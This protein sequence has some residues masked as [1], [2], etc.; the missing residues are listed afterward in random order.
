MQTNCA[1]YSPSGFVDCEDKNGLIKPGES[2]SSVVSENTNGCFGSI[3]PLRSCRQKEE[4]LEMRKAVMDF[5]NSD[6]GSVPWQ[7]DYIRRTSSKYWIKTTRIT[8]HF[9]VFNYN[10]TSWT[11]DV[12][13]TYIRHSEDIYLNFV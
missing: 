11:Q 1:K 5:V 7:N 6:T 8:E 3:K 2:R 12:N 10:F 9:A 4:V 13:C